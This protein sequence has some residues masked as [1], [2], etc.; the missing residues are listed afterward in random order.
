LDPRVELLEAS[1]IL[2]YRAEPLYDLAQYHSVMSGT[3]GCPPDLIPGD[4][5]L[6]STCAIQH[7]AAAFH[8]A[9]RAAALPTP[10]VVSQAPLSCITIQ[11]CSKVTGTLVCPPG[12]LIP[13]DIPLHSTCATRTAAAPLHYPNRAAAL[14]TRA[15]GGQLPCIMHHYA[16]LHHVVGILCCSLNETLETSP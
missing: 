4:T 13:G 6:N 3:L 11:L 12:G 9:R 5:P 16:K 10:T 8:Y 14:L 7:N 1:K 15:V 2:T